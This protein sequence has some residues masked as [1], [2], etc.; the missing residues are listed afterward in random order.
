MFRK[1]LRELVVEVGI[2]WLV[3]GKVKN[4]T[5]SDL[6][7]SSIQ[8]MYELCGRRPCEVYDGT[9]FCRDRSPFLHGS[10]AGGELPTAVENSLGGGGSLKVTARSEIMGDG[11]EKSFFTRHKSP[12]VR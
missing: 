10:G 12:W 9:F 1:W 2:E 6:R 7:R 5:P 3:D 4:F 11:G 8:H